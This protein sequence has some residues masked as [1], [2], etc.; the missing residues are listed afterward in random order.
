MLIY[1]DNEPKNKILIYD[2]GAKVPPYSDT[3]EDFHLSYRT[4]P[5]MP[6]PISWAE[7]LRVECQHFG[8]H[9][10]EQ[11]SLEPAAGSD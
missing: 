10:R 9:P 8:L 1:D 4:G 7:P 2:K 11:K 6:Y 3:E 5:T